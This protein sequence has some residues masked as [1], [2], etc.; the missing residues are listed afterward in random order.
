MSGITR[1]RVRVDKRCGQCG[2]AFSVPNYRKDISKYCSRRCMALAHRVQIV[3]N[4]AECGSEFSHISSRAS[5]AKYCSPT[6][7]QSAMRRRGTVE[8]TCQH[9][10]KIFKGAPSHKRKF[11]SRA[12]INKAH[13]STWRPTFAT[14]RDALFKRGL[15]TRCGR[16]GFDAMPDILGVHHRDRNTRN[17]ALEN[18]EVLCPNCHSLEHRKHIPH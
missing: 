5:K 15:L 3:T 1:S 9:C 18:L 7:Y 6:C 8:Y 16:C 14:A 13:I 12:C 10:S 4:C 11:C 17:N 2:V